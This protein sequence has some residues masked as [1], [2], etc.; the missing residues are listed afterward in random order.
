MPRDFHAKHRQTLLWV[1]LPPNDFCNYHSTRGHAHEHPILAHSTRRLLAVHIE[2]ALVFAAPFYGNSDLPL[3]KKN[4]E[5]HEPRQS[6]R[7]DPTALQTRRKA[8]HGS[9]RPITTPL[10]GGAPTRPPLA[11]M[12]VGR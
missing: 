8:Q 5:S 1:R 6:F 3:S 4:R 11:A 10:A 7:T 2:F 12:D 9:H